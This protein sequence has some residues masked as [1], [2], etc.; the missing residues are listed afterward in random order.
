MSLPKPEEKQIRLSPAPKSDCLDLQKFCIAGGP[1]YTGPFHSI[2]PFLKWVQQLQLF[3]K[4][5]GVVKDNDKIC[6]TGGLLEE[7]QLLDFCATFADPLWDAFKTQLFEVTLP[8]QW[9][10]TL[11]TNLRQMSM[12]S[13]TSFISFSGW[14]QTLQALINFDIS[15]SSSKAS[16]RCGTR[17][18]GKIKN[19]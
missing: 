1:H 16:T 18:R 10:T 17:N 7:T 5:K 3:F 15:P 6:I 8:Q 12:G 11:K 13:T 14:A 19:F 2:E 4:T 9:C